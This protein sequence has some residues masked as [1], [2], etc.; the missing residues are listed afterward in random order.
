MLFGK[1]RRFGLV[2]VLTLIFVLPA[3][4]GQALGTFADFYYDYY[5]WIDLF[6]VF[7]TSASVFRL[8]L[9]KLWGKEGEEE[10][11]A[12]KLAYFS[13]AL[14][15][16]IAIVVWETRSGFSLADIGWLA[17][18][19]LFL[20][21]ISL[22]LGLFTDKNKKK[23]LIL[24]LLGLLFAALFIWFFAPDIW[25]Q[26]PWYIFGDFWWLFAVVIGAIALGLLIYY[27]FKRATGAKMPEGGGGS[28]GATS[29][30]GGRTPDGGR[31]PDSPGTTRRPDIIPPYEE[32]EGPTYPP[33]KA[34]IVIRKIGYFDIDGSRVNKPGDITKSFSDN[35][36][37]EFSSVIEGGS[38]DYLRT[39]EIRKVGP[40]PRRLTRL[41]EKAEFPLGDKVHKDRFEVELN[42]LG[43]EDAYEEKQV[44]LTIQDQKWTETGRGHSGWFVW[45]LLRKKTTPKTVIVST[46]FIISK[47]KPIDVF[48]VVLKLPDPKA[49][50]EFV[51]D[52]E[53]Q[54][55]ALIEPKE[56]RDR[57]EKFVWFVHKN[58]SDKEIRKRYDKGTLLSDAIMLDWS[59]ESGEAILEL[60]KSGTYALFVAAIKKIEYKTTD[61]VLDFVYHYV[62]IHYKKQKIRIYMKEK[63]VLVKNETTDKKPFK[64]KRH[65]RL[66]FVARRGE[67]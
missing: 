34:R 56:M 64:S 22:F 37:V 39:W 45:D 36:I 17:A 58:L 5:G 30:D 49:V 46:K 53:Y 42:L 10:K 9:G 32:P 67:D 12:V 16:S 33:L 61:K 62:V 15:T 11:P 8:A 59:G 27:L 47:I 26:I 57:V 18:L 50:E 41:F 7:L 6:V 52:K 65:S 66:D 3:V 51:S 38:G 2:L 40:L 20:M 23:G 29:S 28:G 14:T 25:Y 63:E 21:V 24:L 1:K 19:L 60:E 44:T 13:L 31:R 43:I 55:L 54:Y 4:F 48:K 35:D